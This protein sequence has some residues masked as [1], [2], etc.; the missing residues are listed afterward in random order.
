MKIHKQ[1]FALFFL[2][3]FSAL[4]IMDLH[5]LSHDDHDEECSI[6]QVASLDSPN[7]FNLPDIS[8]PDCVSTIIR[9][10]EIILYQN[11]FLESFDIKKL[12]NKAPPVL[13]LA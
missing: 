13:D 7:D 2:A 9:D 3:L 10:T 11:P 5:I 12:S 6:C 8:A 1:I 4:Q